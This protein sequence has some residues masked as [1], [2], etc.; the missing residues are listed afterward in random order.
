MVLACQGH[1]AVRVAQLGLELSLVLRDAVGYGAAN[2]EVIL[3]SALSWYFL[4]PPKGPTDLLKEFLQK[5]Q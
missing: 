3:E 2:I 5:P 4:E 1:Q